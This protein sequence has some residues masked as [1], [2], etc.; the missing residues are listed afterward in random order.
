ML[1][2][3]GW[4]SSSQHEW[5]FQKTYSTF[6]VII[7][8]VLCNCFSINYANR[9]PTSTGTKYNFFSFYLNIKWYSSFLSYLG[10]NMKF[11]KNW[12]TLINYCY[13]FN[14]KSFSFLTITTMIIRSN[15]SCL[16]TVIVVWFDFIWNTLKNE[17]EFWLEFSF[18]FW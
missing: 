18:T 10:V 16:Q 14:I 2:L 1:S 7:K 17:R 12:N 5:F 4:S 11:T 9:F 13:H 3:A 15:K 6:R 8:K